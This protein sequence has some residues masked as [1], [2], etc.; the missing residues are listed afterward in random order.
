[1]PLECIA[2]I[3][4]SGGLGGDDRGL[5][6]GKPAGPS[7]HCRGYSA[8]QLCAPGL[9]LDLVCHR[10]NQRMT[11]RISRLRRGRD[12]L[13][14]IRFH[15]RRQIRCVQKGFQQLGIEP[16]ADDGCGV[17]RTLRRGGE[18]I[19]A[20]SDDRLQTGRDMDI[21]NLTNADV[22]AR[23]TL[24][25]APLDQ[26]A[27]DLLGSEWQARRPFSDDRW[28]PGDRRIGTQQSID[29]FADVRITQRL[30]LDRVRPGDNRQ[31]TRI[32]GPVDDQQRRPHSGHHRRE[33]GEQRLADA[34]DPLHILDEV[35]RRRGAGQRHGF[36]ELNKTTTP[37][38]RI[39]NGTRHFGVARAQQVIEQLQILR[40]GLGDLAAHPGPG[41]LRRKADDAE[42]RSQQPGDHLQRD[43]AG[44]GFA[45]RDEHLEAAAP[46]DRDGLTDQPCLA[47]A[48]PT[49]HR[50]DSSRAGTG[51]VQQCRDG[52]LLRPAPNQPGLM[53]G[54][55]SMFDVRGYQAPRRH[56]DVNAF[57]VH[58]LALTE[59]NSILDA[60][61]GRLAEQDTARRCRGLHP[62][63]HPY[64]LTERGVTE[65]GGADLAGDHPAG[66][67]PDAQPQ[68]DPIATGNLDGQ[69]LR[70]L[71]DVQSRETRAKCMSF[72]RD[73]RS[74][75]RHDAV[76]GELVHGAAVALHHGRRLIDEFGH[77]L[78][79]PLGPQRRGDFHRPHHVG[80]QNGHLLVFGRLGALRQCSAAG[81]AE[82]R[83][84]ARLGAAHVAPG[85]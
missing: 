28:Q 14:E 55:E 67:Q 56:A 61:S 45:V 20:G 70:G 44:V 10:V 82:T 12:L 24:E 42:D 3:T 77:H 21:A 4:G 15:E 59:H 46:R 68:V 72:Q 66:I 31:R 79:Q 37:G 39:D 30:K 18:P 60:P 34:V 8:V 84:S 25:F 22:G 51:L 48:G 64:L 11:E 49:R 43:V 63:R 19:D 78:A 73:W 40:P 38:V 26:I 13:D 80:E 17:Q 35:N 50:D 7:F 85:R 69:A 36:D 9:Q 65:V 71:L 27:H 54:F 58:R 5:F 33:V 76:A 83:T 2:Q 32:L 47:D 75:Q 16:R 23:I 29:Q 1:M 57:D 41:L 6:A 74:E 62:L 53:T 81:I 52:A